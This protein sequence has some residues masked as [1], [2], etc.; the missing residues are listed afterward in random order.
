MAIATFAIT[1]LPA[2]TQNRS[3]PK[4]GSSCCSIVEEA[5]KD[6]A[7]IKP[8]MTR[9]EVEVMFTHEGGPDFLI[10]TFYVWRRCPYIKIK[11]SFTLSD[12]T[13]RKESSSDVVKSVS[14][15]YL[16]YPVTD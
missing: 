7:K 14:T 2:H 12:P 1:V 8:G 4:I 15:P 9:A 6:V 5:L 11:V 13:G 10:Q 16:Q 3:V